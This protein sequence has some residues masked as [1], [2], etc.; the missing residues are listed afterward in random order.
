MHGVF[1]SRQPSLLGNFVLLCRCHPRKHR[2][3]DK[4][5]V[6]KEALL[7]KSLSLE[8]KRKKHE[9]VVAKSVNDNMKKN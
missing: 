3:K 2:A 1:T 5:V 8:V 4:W 6:D 7:S 9:K